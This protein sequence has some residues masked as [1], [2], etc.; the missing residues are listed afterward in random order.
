MKTATARSVEQIVEEQIVKWQK[1]RIEKKK[2]TSVYIPRPCMTISREP[3]SGGTGIAAQ[4]A[5]ELGMDLVG[6]KII[7]QVA[8]RTDLSEKVITSLDEKD[9]RRIDSFLDSLFT[10]RHIWPDEY[11]P[12]LSKVIAAIGKQGNT[13]ILGRGGQFLLPPSEAFRVRLSAPKEMRIRN[14]MRYSGNNVETAERYVQKADEDRKAF[15]L[16]HF[17]ADW[18]DSSYYDLVANT[19]S[20]GFEGSITVIKTAFAEWLKNRQEQTK[21]HNS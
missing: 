1:Q 11:L 17:G 4:L 7:Q 3:G 21:D 20:L 14:A 10:A 5:E 8:E 2:E 16:K 9:V 6:R 19:A 18:A 12:H 15:H 13:I